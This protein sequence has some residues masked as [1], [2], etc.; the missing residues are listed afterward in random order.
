MGGHR[1]RHVAISDVERGFT[2]VFHWQRP[3]KKY[4]QRFSLALSTKYK[5]TNAYRKH[6]RVLPLSRIR[7]SATSPV[8]YFVCVETRRYI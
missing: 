8:D 5:V 6:A 4:V 7:Y 1:F 2:E 3:S